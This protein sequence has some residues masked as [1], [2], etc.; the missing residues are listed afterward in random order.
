[1]V[2]LKVLLYFFRMYT[3]ARSHI[4]R[5]NL[6]TL[7]CPVQDPS[8]LYGSETD[9]ERRGGEVCVRGTR[10]LLLLRLMS[11]PGQSE[12]FG[13]NQARKVFEATAPLPTSVSLDEI[14]HPIATP[15]LTYMPTPTPPSLPSSWPRSRLKGPPVKKLDERCIIY[16][17]FI[18]DGNT[19]R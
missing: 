11:P 8:V 6:T 5:L 16:L 14:Q 13:F 3:Q 12:T 2:A 7:L 10:A 19:R 18:V 4:Q 17:T 9:R 1:M 15:L